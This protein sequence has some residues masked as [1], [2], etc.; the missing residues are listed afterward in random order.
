MAPITAS[1]LSIGTQVNVRAPAVS[2]RASNA[3]VAGE[4]ARVRPHVRD[5]HHLLRA[6]DAI[7]RNA[8]IFPQIDLRI[9]PPDRDILGLTGDRVGADHVAVAQK[10][11]A[12]GRLTNTCR[13]LEHGLEHRLQ[14]AWRGAK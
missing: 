8:G 7:D 3:R 5:V 4:V 14:L 6:N 9:T 2:T 11:V 13:A 1:S 12:E 10:Q